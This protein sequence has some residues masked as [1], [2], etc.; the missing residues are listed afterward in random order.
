[1]ENKRTEELLEAISII[2]N[3]KM[4]FEVIGN[5]SNI[6]FS[7]LGYNGALIFTKKINPKL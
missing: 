6:L 3:M 5:A 7:D 4:K 1:M 2:R